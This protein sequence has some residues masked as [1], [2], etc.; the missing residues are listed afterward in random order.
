MIELRWLRDETTP[1]TP[2]CLQWREI[3]EGD[4]G[5]VVLANWQDVPIIEINENE[6]EELVIETA[7]TT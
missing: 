1:P 4:Q 5:I 6:L 7:E 2:D 3:V